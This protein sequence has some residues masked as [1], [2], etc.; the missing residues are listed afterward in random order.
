MPN[1]LTMNKLQELVDRIKGVGVLMDQ[2]QE[3]VVL[4]LLVIA[5]QRGKLE[6]LEEE[7]ERLKNK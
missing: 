1:T 5:F 3:S 4:D 7:L 2:R 6:Q